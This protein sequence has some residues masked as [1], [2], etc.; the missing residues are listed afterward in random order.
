MTFERIARSQSNWSKLIGQ[1]FFGKNALNL[2]R[3]ELRTDK[4]PSQSPVAQTSALKKASP[5]RTKGC[6]GKS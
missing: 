5:E 4:S 1:G 3:S 6:Y 2:D